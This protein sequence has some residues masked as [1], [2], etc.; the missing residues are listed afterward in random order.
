MADR[1]AL[2]RDGRLMQVGTP[3]AIYLRP[4]DLFVARFFCELNEFAGTVRGGMAETPVGRF[5][6]PRSCR[7]QAAIVASARRRSGCVRKARVF[8][9]AC[10][11]ANSSA[12]WT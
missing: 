5:A 7:G 9:L 12:M 4:A 1:M 11:A 10:S 3:E 2:M 6:A 8:R